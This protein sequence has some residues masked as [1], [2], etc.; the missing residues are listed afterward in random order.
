[1]WSL[2]R[3]ENAKRKRENDRIEIGLVAYHQIYS[4]LA[5]WIMAL[6]FLSAVFSLQARPAACLEPKKQ[7][8]GTQVI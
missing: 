8:A 7:F 6:L 2:I 5:V 4:D 1:V 3:L